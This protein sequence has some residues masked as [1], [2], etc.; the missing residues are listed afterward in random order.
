MPEVQKYTNF[1]EALFAARLFSFVLNRPI[2]FYANGDEWTV[3]SEVDFYV[4]LFFYL[5]IR[6][7]QYDPRTEK[8][9]KTNERVFWD[10]QAM[11]EWA[12]WIKENAGT[13]DYDAVEIAAAGLQESPLMRNPLGSRPPGLRDW[14]IEDSIFDETEDQKSGEHGYWNGYDWIYTKEDGDGEDRSFGGWPIPY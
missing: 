7:Y 11:T 6:E 14:Q 1:R 5:H 10:A 9:V 12:L 13:S 3:E 8:A 2:N 4:A